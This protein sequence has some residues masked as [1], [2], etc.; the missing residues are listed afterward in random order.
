MTAAAPRCFALYVS[1]LDDWQLYVRHR[2]NGFFSV[3]GASGLSLEIQGSQSLV[4]FLT[5][6]VGDYNA[7]MQLVLLPATSAQTGFDS[8]EDCDFVNVVCYGARS[9]DRRDFERCVRVLRDCAV[10]S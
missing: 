10:R 7:S 9:W 8:M 6:V 3:D 4:E 2:G 1:V 5:L